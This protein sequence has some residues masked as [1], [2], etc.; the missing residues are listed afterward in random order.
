MEFYI[1]V[2]TKNTLTVQVNYPKGMSLAQ[3]ETA[4]W[5]HVLTHKA[6][7]TEFEIASSKLRGVSEA[8]SASATVRLRRRGTPPT[9]KRPYVAPIC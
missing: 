5:E 6:D 3:V 8:Q 7:G 1:T 4:V 2:Q 9:K